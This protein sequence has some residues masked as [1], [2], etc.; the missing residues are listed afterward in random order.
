M[1]FPRRL[2]SNHLFEPLSGTLTLIPGGTRGI[3]LA[4]AKLFAQKGSRVVILGRDKDRIA[5]VLTTELAELSPPLS[6]SSAQQVQQQHQHYGFQCDVSNQQDIEAVV[7]EVTKIG[8]VDFLINSA[9]IARDSLLIAHSSQD[10][11]TVIATNLMGTIWMNKAIAKGM[12][13]RKK[14]AIINISSVVGIQGN[15]GQSV[16]SSSKAAIIGFSKSLSKE[17]GSRGVTVN[18]IA[19]G[20]IDTDM[21]SSTY[22]GISEDRKKDIVSRTSLGRLG[23]PEDI[24]EAALFLVQAKFITG[25]TPCASMLHKLHNFPHI[26]K[27]IAASFS[28]DDLLSCTLVNKAWNNAICPQL[29]VDVVTHRTVHDDQSSCR[30]SCGSIASCWK[31]S[32]C[33]SGPQGF[34]T[35]K[36]HRNHIRA[37]TCSGDESLVALT[38]SGC[39]N[40]LEINYVVDRGDLTIQLAHLSH[41]VAQNSGLRSLSIEEPWRAS[42]AMEI[43]GG[44]SSLKALVRLLC[45]NHPS[46]TCFYLDTVYYQDKLYG[47]HLLEMLEMRLDAIN[48][49]KV[50][51][52]D[53]ITDVPRSCRG[54]S[55]RSSRQTWPG[56]EKPILDVHSQGL[57]E[58]YSG[59][60]WD[61]EGHKDNYS[62]RDALAVLWDDR[63]G[64]LRVCQPGATL[65]YR[66]KHPI[67]E[68]FPNVCRIR[69]S[70]THGIGQGHGQLLGNLSKL[71]ET[72]LTIFP[73]IDLQSSWLQD[74]M[75][76]QLKSI[77]AVLSGGMPDRSGPPFWNLL[78]DQ[79]RTNLARPLASVIASFSIIDVVS[80]ESLL[81][82]FQ[83]CPN[84][85]NLK[86][87]NVRVEG[88]YGLYPD[89]NGVLLFS[90]QQPWACRKLKMLILSIQILGQPNNV[91]DF[92]IYSDDICRHAMDSAAAIAPWFMAELGRQSAMKILKLS[93]NAAYRCGS[94]PFLQLTIGPDNGLDQLAGLRYL[95]SFSV[96]G[97]VHQVGEIEIAW[98][99]Q[100][101]PHLRKIELP[102]FDQNNPFELAPVSRY[103]DHVPNYRP[104]FPR[105]EIVKVSFDYYACKICGLAPDACQNQCFA[106]FL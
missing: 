97:I 67:F 95:E 73:D 8:P 21:T 44:F 10:M 79:A 30:R 25:Q 66:S 101:W 27:D 86:L 42:N 29:Y 2:P 85:E 57:W 50:L 1:R 32:C 62:N 28:F 6:D 98:M 72:D 61:L 9:G 88:N 33:F 56:R 39:S 100:H 49:D 20:Y 23:R 106:C 34:A 52:L 80:M 15:I 13:R 69:D 68:R 60:R 91:D 83:N 78:L 5:K 103:L 51:F 54:P 77:H 12:M 47:I 11:E 102:I 70:L 24:S 4:T 40:L 99:A 3:G 38:E 76:P 14:G 63:H 96:T 90:R 18:V 81:H 16:Y 94:S 59:G 105:L 48:K 37:I 92:D 71:N 82:I 87:Y 46:I 55:P 35:L 17:L 65:E 45:D 75:P 53:H 26:I 84:L 36:K 89:G 58:Q 64:T 31:S 41:L 93:F 19:P 7:K 74:N 43:E 22:T 104:W